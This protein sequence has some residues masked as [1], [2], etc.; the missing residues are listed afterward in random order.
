M[1]LLVAVVNSAEMTMVLFEIEGWGAKSN[2]VRRVKDRSV[3]V[4]QGLR[5]TNEVRGL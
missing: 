3:T 1:R 2:A 5:R 4:G